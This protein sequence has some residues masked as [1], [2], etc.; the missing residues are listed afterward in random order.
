MMLNQYIR[1]AYIANKLGGGNFKRVLEVGS[2]SQGISE[3]YPYTFTGLDRSTDDY[4]GSKHSVAKNMHFVQGDVFRMPF[5]D[6]S[7]DMVFS[8]DML[9]HLPIHK[10]KK[11]IHEMIRVSK[12][13]IIVAFPCSKCARKIDSFLL[14][15]RVF[16][17][18]LR[19]MRKLPWLEEHIN[20]GFSQEDEIVKSLRKEKNIRIT[21]KHNGFCP[22]W[23]LVMIIDFFTPLTYFSPLFV[24]LLAKTR[25]NFMTKYPA[26]RLVLEIEK[27]G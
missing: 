21:T 1:Y 18:K 27:Y 26:Y 3:L 19:L 23:F 11:A 9:E 8:V 2:G 5:K 24:K 20:N 6:H 10:R 4:S 13:Y 25:W 16:F 17:N 12:K 15:L 14:R 22:V 7:F